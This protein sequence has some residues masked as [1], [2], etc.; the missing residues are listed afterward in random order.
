M[1]IAERQDGKRPITAEVMSRAKR[2]LRLGRVELM[3]CT[4]KGRAF[5][6]TVTE[7]VSMM[8]RLLYFL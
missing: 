5:E 8:G 4:M 3:A 2:M 1:A 6:K 7:W